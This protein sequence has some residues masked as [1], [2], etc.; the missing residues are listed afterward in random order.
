M[1]HI[2]NREFAAYLRSLL[3]ERNMSASDL[4]RAIW[5][6]APPDELGYIKA[7]GRDRMSNYLR[8][9]V[10]RT[11]AGSEPRGR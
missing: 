2:S 5:G 10:R 6:D 8:G 4:C 11:G 3:V 9:K 7:R 1:D